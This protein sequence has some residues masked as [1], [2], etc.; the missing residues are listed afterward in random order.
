MSVYGSEIKKYEEVMF[1]QFHY[2]VLIIL[3]AAAF[4]YRCEGFED[5]QPFNFFY[6]FSFFSISLYR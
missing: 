3:M 2:Y 1:V 5:S 6:C 4:L